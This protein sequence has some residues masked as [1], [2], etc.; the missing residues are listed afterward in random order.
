ML[1][2]S[3]NRTDMRMMSTFFH[4]HPVAK[5]GT[6]YSTN[7]AGDAALKSGTRPANPCTNP[8][9]S[10]PVRA[11]S[12]HWYDALCLAHRIVVSAPAG[13]TVSGIDTLRDD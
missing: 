6:V 3:C 7:L 10:L 9:I 8:K 4:G 12:A 13:R 5:A 1:V 2:S 11:R